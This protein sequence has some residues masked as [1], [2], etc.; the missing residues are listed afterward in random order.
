[1]GIVLSGTK[2]GL[3]LLYYLQYRVSHFLKW[4]F[5][6]DFFNVFYQGKG[7]YHGKWKRRRRVVDLDLSFTLY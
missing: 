6:I 3:L 1:L 2:P 7:N 4:F 5:L